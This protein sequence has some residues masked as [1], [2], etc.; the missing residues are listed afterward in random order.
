MQKRMV[1]QALVVLMI[2]MH[3]LVAVAVPPVHLSQQ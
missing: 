2:L 1:Q 3:L